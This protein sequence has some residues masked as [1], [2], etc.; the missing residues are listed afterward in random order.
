MSTSHY[1]S[2]PAQSDIGRDTIRIPLQSVPANTRRDNTTATIWLFVGI[3]VL[4]ADALAMRV[5]A[6]DAVEAVIIALLTMPLGILTIVAAIQA[7]R[8]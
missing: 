3:I 4:C 2:R 6:E 7:R 1:A 5:F 8:A